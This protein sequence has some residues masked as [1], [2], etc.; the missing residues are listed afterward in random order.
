MRAIAVHELAVMES[1]VEMVLERVATPVA[2]V[3]LEIGELAGVD[4]EALRFCFGI[5]TED[6]TLAKAT[7]EI[8][9]VGGRAR[10]QLCGV[11]QAIHSLAT[12][13]TCG[14][15]DRVLVAGHELKLKDVEV[16]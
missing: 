14:S 13:C 8:V 15:F 4:V 6:T 11:E 2:L 5:C 1:V 9:R 3:R 10:C 12:P 7:L 16:W